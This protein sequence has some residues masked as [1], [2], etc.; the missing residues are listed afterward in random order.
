MA[1]SPIEYYLKKLEEYRTE[2]LDLS[3]PD[4]A[5]ELGIPF[6]THRN[7]YRRTKKG[8]I[9]LSSMLDG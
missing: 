1:E 9:F 8:V 3:K 7:W 4:M 2:D 6:E 5:N